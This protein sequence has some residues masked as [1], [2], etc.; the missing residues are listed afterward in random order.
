MS[1][2]KGTETEKNLLR[3]FTGE[4]SAASR[5]YIFTQQARLEGYEYIAQAFEKAA[6][7]EREHAKIW[8]KWMNDNETSKT[9]QNLEI[10]AK[11]ENYEWTQMYEQFAQK[12]REEG[13]ESLADLFGY[14]AGVEKEHENKFK[15][16]ALCIKNENIEPDQNGNYK[17][18]CSSCE[19]IIEQK[20]IPDYCPICAGEDI[21][22]YKI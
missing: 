6:K 13:F 9:L 2:I 1:D 12:A 10:S 19:A 21:F 4:S 7:N 14:V 5:Y 3:A 17:W 20:D 18:T 22:F 15:K 8:F 11:N 16:L